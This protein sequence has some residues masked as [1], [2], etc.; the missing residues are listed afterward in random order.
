MIETIRQSHERMDGSGPLGLKGEFILP[1][2]QILA[3]A[4]SFVAITSPR[5]YRAGKNTEE[6]IS[7]LEGQAGIDYSEDVIVALKHYIGNLGG[8]LAW[9]HFREDMS[10]SDD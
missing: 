3:V 9:R 5:S 8:R 2:A 6:A 1:T 7:I 4:N 10:T